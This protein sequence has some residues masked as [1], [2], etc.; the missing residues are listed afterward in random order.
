MKYNQFLQNCLSKAVGI[1]S[2]KTSGTGAGAGIGRNRM[3]G[4]IGLLDT[5][6]IGS[7]KIPEGLTPQQ[8]EL[9]KEVYKR[10]TVHKINSYL[11]EQINHINHKRLIGESIKL[12]FDEH[13]KPP[14]NAPLEDILA[15]R[16][17]IE[18][19]IHM[20]DAICSAMRISLSKIREIED[21][22]IESIG[23]RLEK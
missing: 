13:G 19:E 4:K 11:E 10:F 15:A 6:P 17:K 9:L 14:A 20:L 18:A 22:A 7:G 23:G 5:E 21:L 12:L 2:K 8:E 1:G 16:K 3:R